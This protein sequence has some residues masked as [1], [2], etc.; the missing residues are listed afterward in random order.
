MIRLVP[1]D[2]VSLERDGAFHYALVLGKISYFGANWAYVFHVTSTQ[3]MD[4]QA[5]IES[6]NGFNAFVDFIHAKRD[7]RLQRIGQRCE[8]HAFLGP[9]LMKKTFTTKGKAEQWFITDMQHKE[10]KR[11]ATLTPQE[12]DYPLDQMISEGLM[13]RRIRERWIPAK[14]ERI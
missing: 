6:Q 1:G 11:V 5:V 12:R 13:I 8:V 4:A 14:D 10:V 7:Q 9:G 2:L 3:V